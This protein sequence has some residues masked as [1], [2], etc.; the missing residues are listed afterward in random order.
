MCD[1]PAAAATLASYC[2]DHFFIIENSIRQQCTGQN[3]SNNGNAECCLD[4]KKPTPLPDTLAG[5]RRSLAGDIV[6]ADTSTD[7]DSEP[8]PEV[9]L[10]EEN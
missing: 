3:N 9:C 5:T 4:C 7:D 6:V 1:P 8:V 10:A 2:T